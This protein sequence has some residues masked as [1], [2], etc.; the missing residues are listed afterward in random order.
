MIEIDGVFDVVKTNQSQE[1]G[2]NFVIVNRNKRQQAELIIHEIMKALSLRITDIGDNDVEKHV[3]QCPS[4][5]SRLSQGGYT[6]EAAELH[7]EIYDSATLSKSFSRTPYF[8][9]G[10]QLGIDDLLDE[11]PSI[12]PPANAWKKQQPANR[13][14]ILGNPEHPNDDRPLI[15]MN[16]QSLANTFASFR[17]EMTSVVTTMMEIDK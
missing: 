11:F 13:L 12:P 2:K 5:Q 16:D 15:S 6:M 1:L 4:L 7:K 17:T 9:M 8:E 14:T 3:H 10:I